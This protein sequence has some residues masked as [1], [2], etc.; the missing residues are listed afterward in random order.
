VICLSHIT[1]PTA[2]ILPVEEVCRRA[3]EANIISVIDGAHAPG[4]IELSLNDMGADYYAGNAHKWLCAPKGS[5][6]LYS[7]Q[8]PDSLLEP[9]VVSHGWSNSD[10][11]SR[12][13]DYFG[14]TG[15]IDPSSYLSISAAI[16]FQEEHDWAAVRRACHA[17]ASKTR[18]AIEDLTGLEPICPDSEE[19]YSQMFTARLPDQFDRELRETLWAQHRIEVPVSRYQDEHPMIRVSV[20]AYNSHEDMDRLLNALETAMRGS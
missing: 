18:T 11:S 19:W 9:L 6:V 16:D 17:L 2:L 15:T 8:G 5:A 12:L 20:Q 10:S 13:E 7:R 4:Q 3:R 1:A 14:W